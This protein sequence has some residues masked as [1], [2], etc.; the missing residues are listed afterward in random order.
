MAQQ[1][2]SQI[3]E[4]VL[5]DPRETEDGGGKGAWLEMGWQGKEAGQAPDDYKK[6]PAGG[7]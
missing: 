7:S 3:S 5:Y 1:L 6:N 2:R 4:I